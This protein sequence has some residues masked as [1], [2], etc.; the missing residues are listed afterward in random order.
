MTVYCDLV[1]LLVNVDDM[2]IATSLLTV[3]AEV[4]G[5]FSESFRFKGPRRSKAFP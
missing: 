2:L 3:L 1:L 5:N 4:K